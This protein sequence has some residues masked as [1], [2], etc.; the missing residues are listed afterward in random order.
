[1]NTYTTFTTFQDLPVILCVD[2]VARALRISRANAYNL[3]RSEGFP[4]L[5][6]G[7]RMSVPKEKLIEWIE[8]N[9]AA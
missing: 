7:K 2:E 9:T 1:M 5:K 6:I 3:M 4:T 8:A